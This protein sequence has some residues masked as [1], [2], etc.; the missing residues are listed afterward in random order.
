MRGGGD[1]N[2]WEVPGPG[3]SRANGAEKYQC[4]AW[5]QPLADG[6]HVLKVGGRGLVQACAE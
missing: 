6:L 1:P 4:P 2:R 5:K 3:V